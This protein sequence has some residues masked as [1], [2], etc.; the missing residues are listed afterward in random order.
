M[1]GLNLVLGRVSSTGSGHGDILP[2]GPFI[3]LSRCPPPGGSLNGHAPSDEATS[4]LPEL[5]AG[6]RWAVLVEKRQIAIMLLENEIPVASAT[7]SLE[8]DAELD[9]REGLAVCLPGWLSRVTA[10]P[11]RTEGHTAERIVSGS[12]VVR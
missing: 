3:P 5:P 11:V 1:S 7:E 4:S 10:R 12:T 8:R 6:M 2:A 9:R